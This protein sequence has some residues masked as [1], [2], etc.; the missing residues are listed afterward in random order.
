[1]NVF[2]IVGYLLIMY[3]MFLFFNWIVVGFFGFS[4]LVKKIVVIF[5]SYKVLL[6]VLKVFKFLII[7]VGFRRFMFIVCVIVYLMFFV[8]DLMIVCKWVIIIDDEIEEDKLK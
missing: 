7:N 8:L 4:L 5:G 2:I 6:F 3:V 1:M